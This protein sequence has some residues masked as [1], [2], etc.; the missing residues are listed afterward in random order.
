MD[1]LINKQRKKKS[2]GK[3]FFC[4]NEDYAILDCHRIVEGRDGGKYTDHNTI[5]ACANCHR[6]IHDEQ[7]VID[8][9]YPS[10]SGKKVLRYWENGE[11]LWREC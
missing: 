3:C 8:R 11:E 6:K 10:T 5:V 2:V 9:K 4:G 7:I 1:R